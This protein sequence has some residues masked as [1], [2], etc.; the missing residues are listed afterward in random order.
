MTNILTDIILPITLILI[1]IICAIILSKYLRKKYNKGDVTIKTNDSNPQVKLRNSYCTEEE[2]V[3]LEAVHK[4]LPRE[5]IAFPNVGVSKLVEPKNNLIDYKS[6][7]AKYVDVCIFLRKDMK[8][9]LVIDLYQPSPIAQQL[10]Q[11]D[12]NVNNV[13][14]AVKIPVLHKQIKQHYDLDDLRIE[15]LSNIDSKTVASLKDKII[16]IS[17]NKK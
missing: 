15:L 16:D 1:A 17:V 3:F 7:L 11:F 13:L 9:I 2:M 5:F 10:K 12:D 6:V 14:K 8:P 4:A